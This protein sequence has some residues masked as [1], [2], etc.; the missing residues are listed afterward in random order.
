M[1]PGHLNPLLQRSLRLE[2]LIKGK[3]NYAKK[4]KLCSN[5][6]DLL[7]KQ[8]ESVVDIIKKTNSFHRR[9]D[10]EI[11]VNIDGFHTKTLS[12]TDWFLISYKKYL[13]RN[14]V[15]Y[16][17]M[18]YSFTES[19][20]SHGPCGRSSKRN[21]NGIGIDAFQ[22]RWDETYHQVETLVSLDGMEPILREDSNVKV[23]LFEVGCSFTSCN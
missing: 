14:W 18:S 2:I 17:I 1:N 21:L 9:H 10:D 16:C 19:S 22:R 8:L 12:E 5:L 20:P 23:W 4:Q 15:S 6:Q 3:M 7:A 11:E 13:S